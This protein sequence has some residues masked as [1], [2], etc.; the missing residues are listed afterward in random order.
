MQPGILARRRLA[1]PILAAAFRAASLL[2]PV[3]PP[4]LAAAPPAAR[5]AIARASA[6]R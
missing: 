6:L 5:V 2:R 4:M 1:R 3:P